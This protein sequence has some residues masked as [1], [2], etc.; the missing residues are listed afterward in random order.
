MTRSAF[1]AIC[2]SN[3]AMQ[4]TFC[5]GT[6]SRKSYHY[7]MRRIFLIV[8]IALL[9]LR[10]WVGD[11]MAMEMAAQSVNTTNSVATHAHGARAEGQFDSEKV[12]S[13]HA[14]CPGHAATA[15]G[16]ASTASDALPEGD[17]D[18]ASGHCNTCGVCQICHTVA[19]ANALTGSAPGFIPHPLPAIGSTRFA[20]AVTALSQKPPIS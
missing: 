5:H 7:Y 1:A 2:G 12:A 11:V 15:S 13:T 17:S 10:G 4:I 6:M 3:P 8:M 20:S 9:P 16:Q 14:E 18:S 19:L